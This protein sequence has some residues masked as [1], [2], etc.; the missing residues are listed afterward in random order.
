MKKMTWCVTFLAF[1]A[2]VLQAAY[3]IRVSAETISQGLLEEAMEAYNRMDYRKALAIL[4]QIGDASGVNPDQRILVPLYTGLSYLGQGNEPEAAEAFTRVLGEKPDFTL[5]PQVWSPKVTKAFERARTT[6]LEQRRREDQQPPA[7]IHEVVLA[8]QSEGVPVKIT[9]RV[10]DDFL[11]DRA[12][13]RY[14][15]QGD[16]AFRSLTMIPGEQ[17]QFMVV[18]PGSEISGK[19]ID[20]YIEAV[21]LAGNTSLEGTASRP[22]RVAVDIPSQKKAWYR[23]W[24]VWALAG[25]LLA[26]GVG[27]AL[28]LS[29]GDGEGDRSNLGTVWVTWSPNE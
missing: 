25:A 21:D 8:K 10:K 13:L 19:E 11:L 26:G 1:H 9:A 16:P 28:A 24:W 20:Y 3:P 29:S 27:T 17:G 7:I 6:Y 5:D 18:I 2:L 23:K 12:T 15:I 22:H 4:G 14:R